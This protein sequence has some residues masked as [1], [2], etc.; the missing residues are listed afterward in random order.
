MKV[1]VHDDREFYLFPRYR[2]WR[3]MYAVS[4]LGFKFLIFRGKN[5]E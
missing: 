1:E 5:D 4:W 3:H 2:A